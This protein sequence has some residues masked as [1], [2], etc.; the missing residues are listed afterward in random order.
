MRL[1]QIV[2]LFSTL[3]LVLA[4]VYLM[5]YWGE[6]GINIF[7]FLSV[8]DYIGQAI[9]PLLKFMIGILVCSV[10]Y[11]LILSRTLTFI[12][13]HEPSDAELMVDGKL[14]PARLIGNFLVALLLFIPGFYHIMTGTDYLQIAIGLFMVSIPFYFRYRSKYLSRF[15]SQNPLY[16]PAILTFILILFLIPGYAAQNAKVTKNSKVK[17]L[18]NN[19]PM[20]NAVFVGKGGDNFF[21]WKKDESNLVIYNSSEISTVEIGVVDDKFISILDSLKALFFNVESES[22]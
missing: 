17:L 22:K 12:L 11:G 5:Y 3:A 16:E 7:Q 18:I 14:P 8:S 1:I 15:I 19:L 10:V 4:T 2:P 20:H 13:K 9:S 6:F 21:I